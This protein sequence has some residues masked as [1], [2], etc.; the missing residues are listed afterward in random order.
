GESGEPVEP[1]ARNPLRSRSPPL[2][3]DTSAFMHEA[4]NAA[5]VP[6]VVICASALSSHR[7]SSDGYP[8]FPSNSTTAAS[9][10]STPTR[11]FHI[12]QPV[13]E[14]QNTRS[15]ARAST[16]NLWCLS[17]SSRIPPWLCTIALGRPV[18]PEL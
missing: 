8:G 16:C 7:R 6:N 18:V 15:P 3:T 12:I 1:T 9:V 14:N 5:L 4:M 10:S 11:K 13:V 2:V 17:C